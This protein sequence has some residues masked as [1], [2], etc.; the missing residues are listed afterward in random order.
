MTLL[1][2]LEAFY[3][4]HGRCGELDSEVTDGEPGWVV[5]TCTC[6]AKIARRVWSSTTRPFV[7]D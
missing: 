7:D 5:M 1:G 3:Q 6:G 4:E 2:D